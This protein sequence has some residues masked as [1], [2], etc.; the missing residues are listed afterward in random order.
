M[1]HNG[2]VVQDFGLH[3]YF[4][5]ATGE[6]VEGV[7]VFYFHAHSF[8][9]NML[10][11]I[12]FDGTDWSEIACQY[13]DLEESTSSNMVIS[14]DYIWGK[15][16]GRFYKGE[17]CGVFS[18]PGPFGF[19]DSPFSYTPGEEFL[20]ELSFTP[21]T[22]LSHG[23]LFHSFGDYDLKYSDTSF[24]III[25]DSS[26]V[27]ME[28]TIEHEF[29]AWE[30]VD[31]ILTKNFLGEFELSINGTEVTLS[32]NNSDPLAWVGS[33]VGTGLNFY[34][35]K[36]LTVDGFKS[37]SLNPS[38]PFDG[39]EASRDAEY[40]KGFH[41]MRVTDS[42]INDDSYSISYDEVENKLYFCSSDG[43][44]FLSQAS[45]ELMTINTTSKSYGTP[46]T[47]F[48]RMSVV[49]EGNK[50]LFQGKFGSDLVVT[51]ANRYN[52]ELYTKD[53]DFWVRFKPTAVGSYSTNLRIETFIF[54]S[55]LFG[56]AIEA[57]VEDEKD[58]AVVR[59]GEGYKD[60]QRKELTA[61]ETI[62]IFN[63]EGGENWV[64][65]PSTGE[66]VNLSYGEYDREQVGYKLQEATDDF[67]AFFDT[68]NI[69]FEPRRV[70]DTMTDTN[71]KLFV[72]TAISMARIEVSYTSDGNYSFDDNRDYGE[73]GEDIETGSFDNSA[74]LYMGSR[75]IAIK[76]VITDQRE[77]KSLK[78][79]VY[80]K[81]I[82]N[83]DVTSRMDDFKVFSINILS[84][85]MVTINGG[86]DG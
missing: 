4:D 72:K 11:S 71:I 16:A 61:S 40:A 85:G 70:D 1:Y 69:L 10:A 18:T 59:F 31:L 66:F 14:D 57:V 27:I 22:S 75:Q 78:L 36:T 17:R 86:T 6:S 60:F 48:E 5:T 19:C 55:T 15:T 33:K 80:A 64:Y 82:D 44:G 42:L 67:E 12:T 81:V 30:M 46:V 58:Y 83:D 3:S 24:K 51:D 2:D 74:V 43:F 54:L 34:H 41:T 50:V 77:A 29:E 20:V 35:I 21:N 13:I 37:F 9:K 49:F 39:M 8:A 25:E 32:T 56:V 28:T 47:T 52:G 45:I 53:S 68:I 62:N 23:H 79:R 63:R 7:K 76:E 84:E 26:A 65:N 38:D 73:L